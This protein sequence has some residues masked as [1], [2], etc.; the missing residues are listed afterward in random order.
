[1]EQNIQDGQDSKKLYSW[2]YPDEEC[3]EKEAMISAK[4]AKVISDKVVEDK[5]KVE[6]AK[7]LEEISNRVKEAAAKGYSEIDYDSIPGSVRTQLEA[8]GYKVGFVGGE[9]SYPSYF[10]ISW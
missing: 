5:N 8:I 1:M 6:Y 9:Y 4:E 7:I 3:T 2:S 10:T